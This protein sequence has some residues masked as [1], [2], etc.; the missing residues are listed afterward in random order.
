MD[1]LQPDVSYSEQTVEGQ[2]DPVATALP[3]LIGYTEKGTDYVPTVVN[4]LADYETKFGGPADV[5]GSILYYAVWH[6]FDNGGQTCLVLSL[7]TYSLAE[8]ISPD[9]LISALDDNRIASAVATE[10]GITLVAIPDMTLLPDD[11]SNHWA[12]AWLALL[13]ICEARKGTFGLFDAPETAEN[14]SACVSAFHAQSPA[15]PE[16]GAAY[17]PR[18]VTRYQHTDN[19]TPV[20]LPPSASLA[21]VIGMVDDQYGIWRAPA[22]IALSQVIQPSQ[23]WLQSAGLF[24]PTGVSINLIRSFA[25]KGV[26]VWGCRTLV[27]EASSPWLYVQVRRLVSYI[28]TQVTA[29]GRHF[30]FE[31][32]NALTWIRFRGL[33]HVWLREL[34]MNGGLYGTEEQEAFYVQIGLN[35]T[36]TQADIEQGRMIMKIGLAVAYPAEFIEVSLMFD[37][38][39]G[40][41]ST[42]VNDSGVSRHG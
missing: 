38:R 19:T 42:P 13:S 18:L 23:S 27:S 5:N 12:K 28:E 6:Y 11:D 22:N 15:H 35:E 41:V 7:G 3:L 31:V 2:F 36:M 34:W 20:T 1:V 10:D 32:N 8:S 25:G 37:T 17:W 24:Q 30:V 21:A 40:V 33:V 14:A 4:S 26:R 9:G 39:M 29:I 16:L